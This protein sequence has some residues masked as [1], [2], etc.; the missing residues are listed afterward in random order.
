MIDDESLVEGLLADA[1]ANDGDRL[2]GGKKAILD[3]FAE[4]RRERNVAI[5]HEIEAQSALKTIAAA[6]GLTYDVHEPTSLAERVRAACDANVGEARVEEVARSLYGIATVSAINV[7]QTDAGARQDRYDTYP[8]RMWA[9]A[10]AEKRSQFR[11]TARRILE[12]R[13]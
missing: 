2:A 8:D 9:T 3:R 7:T 1:E 6:A 11:E 5:A 10:D 13:S 4:L 12:K